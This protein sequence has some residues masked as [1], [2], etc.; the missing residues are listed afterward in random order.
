MKLSRQILAM[1]DGV[2]TPLLFGN[3]Y[4]SNADGVIIQD[5]FYAETDENG[6]FVIDDNLPFEYIS[7]SWQNQITVLSYQQIVQQPVITIDIDANQLDTVIV[8][9]Q[10]TANNTLLWVALGLLTAKILHVI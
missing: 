3:V 7:I 5:G 10:S 4:S 8:T 2:T 6:R 9:G 1:M